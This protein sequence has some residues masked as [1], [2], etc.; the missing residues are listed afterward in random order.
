MTR[1]IRPNAVRGII[2]GIAAATASICSLFLDAG[3]V[4]AKTPG[5]T[6]CF[7]GICHKVKSIAETQRLVGTTTIARTSFYDDCKVDRYNPCTLTSSG[8]VFKPWRADNAA[9]PIYPDG[10]QLLVWHPKTKNAA[11]VRV[12]SAGPYHS[13]RTLDVSRATA[14]RLGFKSAGVAALHVQVLSAPTPQEARYKKHREYPSVAGPIG[15]YNSF[16]LALASTGS[17][18]TPAATVQVAA[19]GTPGK[20]KTVRAGVAKAAKSGSTT[21]ANKA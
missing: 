6:H 8:E 2:T 3:P 1:I 17:R 15:K 5:G 20:A 14:E 18:G 13:N 21:P 7:F 16:E 10:T 19:K 11:V 4:A 12:N 9:S